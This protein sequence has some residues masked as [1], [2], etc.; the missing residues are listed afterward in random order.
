MKDNP[1]LTFKKTP[2]YIYTPLKM[3]LAKHRKIISSIQEKNR[4]KPCIHKIKPPKMLQTKWFFQKEFATYPLFKLNGCATNFSYSLFGPNTQSPNITIPA[5]NTAFYTQHN[6]AQTRQT[7]GY[8]PYP[9]YPKTQ[10]L[11]YTTSGNKSIK[12]STLTYEKSISQAEGFFQPI[13]LQAIKVTENS[14]TFHHLPVVYGRYNPE[15]DTGHNNQVWLTSVVSTK[16]W[17]PTT[18]PDLIFS[19]EPLYVIF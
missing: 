2:T 18:T 1:H 13:V 8:Y 16:D 7:D 4:Q 3:L 5:L 12:I 6:W 19:E 10:G 9:G 15:E 14:T 17:Q 11:T